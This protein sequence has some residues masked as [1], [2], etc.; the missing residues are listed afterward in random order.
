[1]R[2]QRTGGTGRISA[3]PR[4]VSLPDLISLKLDSYRVSPLRRLKDKADVTELIQWK[5]LPRDLPVAAPVRQLYT[6]TW[7]G[8]QTESP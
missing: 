8:L 7:D 2:S 6:D 1:M 3:E 4:L 5:K